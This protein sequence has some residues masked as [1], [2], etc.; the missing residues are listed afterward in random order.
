M[1][2]WIVS[3]LFS[4]N[5]WA[6]SATLDGDFRLV[7]PFA[8]IQGARYHLA[9][10]FYQNAALDPGAYWRGAS[11][12]DSLL[13]G[14]NGGSIDANLDIH[15]LVV[16]F[17]GTQFLVDLAYFENPLEPGWPYWRLSAAEAFPG[18]ITS[19]TGPTL[20]QF[21]AM[22]PCITGC[23]GQMDLTCLMN[24]MGNF[25]IT[26]A[27]DNP[28]ASNLEIA[29]PPGAVFQPENSGSQPMMILDDQ[30]ILAPPGNSSASL[31]AYCLAIDLAPPGMDDIYSFGAAATAS[32]LVEII[33]LTAEK[34]LTGADQRRIQDVVWNCLD[35]GEISTEDRNFL[36]GL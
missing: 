10:D 36:E 2:F 13:S 6:A 21:Q 18:S 16:F 3:I 28:T 9:L 12:A 7:M 15:D 25:F 29:I 5:A 34:D 11:L 20:E 14:A 30:T 32:C 17:N 23:M 33:N 26:A 1:V 22:A 8:S 24:F 27:V 4:S 35:T 31:T 19:V